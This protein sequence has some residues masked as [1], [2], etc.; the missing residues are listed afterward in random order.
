MKPEIIGTTLTY[1]V[2]VSK[3]SPKNIK[4]GFLDLPDAEYWRGYYHPTVYTTL[5]EAKKALS[6]F[7]KG[8]IEK[9]R[10]ILYWGGKQS[11]K[12]TKILAA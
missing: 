11:S 8:F 10:Y 6:Y 12:I 7:E 3:D 5:K 9:R 1:Q 2:F 4:R